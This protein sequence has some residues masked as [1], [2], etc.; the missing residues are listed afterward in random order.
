MDVVAGLGETNVASL[1]CHV[2]ATCCR[3]IKAA[4]IEA[5]TS[6]PWPMIMT[7]QLLLRFSSPSMINDNKFESEREREREKL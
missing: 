5:A 7:M 4:T 3:S 1:N 6:K 2:A